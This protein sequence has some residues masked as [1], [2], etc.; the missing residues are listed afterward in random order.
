MLEQRRDVPHLQTT[1]CIK[2]TRG[3][4]SNDA[5][6]NGIPE[7]GKLDAEVQSSAMAGFGQIVS[8]FD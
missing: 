2:S 5:V 4:A 8:I 7:G 6:Q 1:L 3:R